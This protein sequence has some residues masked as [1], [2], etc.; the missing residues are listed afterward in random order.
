MTDLQQLIDRADVTDV[1]MALA[2]LLD[3]RGGD[4]AAIY[5]P[6]VVVRGPL[7]ELR[8]I[9]A[10]RARIAASAGTTERTQHHVTGMRV[11][12]EGDEA[13]VQAT[14]LVQFYEVRQVP[15]RMSGLFVEYLLTRRTE[16]WRLA[17][18]DISLEW[19]I[20]D[21]PA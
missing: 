9:E 14:E 8:G 12:V 13:R 6:E 10:V 17:E 18:V 16:G 20:G 21:L 4:P 11:T 1:V 3:R 2:A 15:H 5:A 7:G 19:L